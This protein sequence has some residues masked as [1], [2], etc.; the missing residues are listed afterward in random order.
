MSVAAQQNGSVVLPSSSSTAA[1][2][3]KAS[4]APSEVGW[5]FVPQYYTFL[6]NDPSKLHCFYSKRS[7]LVHGTEQEEVP[8]CIGQ[9]Q[10]HEKI[11][12]LGYQDAKVF[13]SNVD[14]Q[15][16]AAG[17][18][19]I[20]VLG[21]MSNKGGAW[22]KF[23]QTFFLAEQPNGYFV[24]ND[25]FRYLKDEEEAEEEAQDVDDALHD[26]I[27]EAESKGQDVVHQIELQSGSMPSKQI[28]PASEPGSAEHAAVAAAQKDGLIKPQEPTPASIDEVGMDKKV[29]M[30]D[31]EDVPAPSRAQAEATVQQPVNPGASAAA[32]NGHG[33]SAISPAEEAAR[34]AV[35]S[36]PKTW[37]N[38]AASNAT[39]WGTTVNSES[40]GV[41]SARDSAAAPA[42]SSN[43]AGAASNGSA[44][45]GGQNS[46]NSAQVF[47]KN[48]V[49]EHM[50][51][52]GLQAALEAKFG[53][54][55]ECQ[56]VAAKAV[57]F[58]EFGSAEAA[59]KAIQ[60]SLPTSQGG[61]GG[62]KV[63]KNGWQVIV[64]E[65]RKPSERGSVGAGAAN[66]GGARTAR[67]GANIGNQAGGRGGARGGA[68]GG[69]SGGRGGRA[70]AS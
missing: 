1:N 20:Q 9:Q 34:N 12:S 37:A 48:V 31:P 27:V 50:P 19:V 53:P 14:S 62:V 56:V 42:R 58:A 15:A 30:V 23:A 46:Y 10:I 38:L 68:R 63:G 55:K 64:E 6:N 16:S 32:L 7:T 40:R 24:L 65:K 5:L 41:S 43:A 61:E 54:M 47:I 57:A 25:I 17:G 22:R 33:S 36:G 59:R 60:L 39:R 4:A 70:P 52:E 3:A 18:I 69:S 44:S 8:L 28:A 66:A 13:V 67:G 51:A 29:T 45:R 11:V 35:S 26:E 2:P 49:A 21:E